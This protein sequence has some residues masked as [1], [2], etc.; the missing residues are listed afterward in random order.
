MGT[1]SE[2]GDNVALI[3]ARGG[4]KGLPGKN[5]RSFH[6]KPLLAWS[7][8]QARSAALVNQVILSTDAPEI[9][10]MGKWHGADAPFLRPSA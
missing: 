9:A 3:P 10:R 5:I 2:P 1:T 8:D 7:I 4:S 6:G